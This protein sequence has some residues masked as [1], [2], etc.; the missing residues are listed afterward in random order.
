[1]TKT[2]A[3]II[4]SMVGGGAERVISI[5][6]E[7]YVK[8]GYDVHL[9]IFRKTEKSYYINSKIK[10]HYLSDGGGWLKRNINLPFLLSRKIKEINADVYI[11]FCVMENC[12][13]C[14]A[15]LFNRKTLIISERNAPNNEKLS[16]HWIILRRILYRVAAGIVFQTDE[17]RSCYPE[18]L[19]RRSTVIPN[20]IKDIEIQKTD[21]SP[22]YSIAAVGRLASQKNYPLL[23]SAFKKMRKRFP[24]YYLDIYGDG[25]LK[26]KILEVVEK[27]ELTPYVRF[28]G[29]V[30][31]VDHELIKSDIY[32]MS[33][34]Y[35]GMPNALMEAMALGM[36]SIS[37]D[38]PSGGPRTLINSESNGIL[39]PINND[40]LLAEAIERLSCDE[41]LRVKIGNEAK[42]IAEIY[43]KKAIF[44]MWEKYTNSM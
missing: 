21:Y 15:N 33:S 17:A 29:F 36:P 37:T 32:V 30:T 42:K 22:K 3:F 1:M 28:H 31:D 34:D 11:S 23:I 24:D 43:N 35:E 25:P 27:N 39:V 18:Y 40:L 19:Q 26:E 10:C 9:I 44:E 41:N 8:N 5:V 4:G 12:M 16:M 20:P 13:A 38:C 14:L 6:S 2:I 7:M